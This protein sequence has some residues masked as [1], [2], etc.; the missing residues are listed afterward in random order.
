MLRDCRR[1]F[2]RGQGASN[3]FG[4]SIREEL[5]SGIHGVHGGSDSIVEVV[6]RFCGQFGT[7]PDI[8]RCRR[9]TVRVR[10]NLV[11]C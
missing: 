7:P 2:K 10:D 1:T 3:P 11:D 5:I 9:I 8:V 6:H 4:A